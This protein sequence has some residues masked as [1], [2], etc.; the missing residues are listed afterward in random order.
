MTRTGAANLP[1]K[2]HDASNPDAACYTPCGSG[3]FT[4]GKRRGR[5]PTGSLPSTALKIPFCDYSFLPG[6]R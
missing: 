1:P 4:R 5:P 6:F 3:L 2:Q